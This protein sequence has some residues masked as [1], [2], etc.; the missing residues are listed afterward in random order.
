M[1]AK[2]ARSKKASSPCP[3]DGW[4]PKKTY[5]R[6]QEG[7][8][9]VGFGNP[10][11]CDTQASITTAVQAEKNPPTGSCPVLRIAAEPTNRGIVFVNVPLLYL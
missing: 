2:R 9:H 8:V 6:C 7:Q 5:S 10:F 4:S 11:L 1:P 3:G